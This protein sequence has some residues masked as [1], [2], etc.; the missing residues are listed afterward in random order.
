MCAYIYIYIYMYTYVCLCMNMDICMHACM[1]VCMYVG[2]YP[3]TVTCMCA[4]MSLYVYVVCM[5]VRTYCGTRT[6]HS[7]EQLP[8]VENS[9]S[10]CKS[11]VQSLEGWEQQNSGAPGRCERCESSTSGGTPEANQCKG[12]LDRE[13]VKQR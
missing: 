6:G 9:C 4:R 8:H 1:D 7:L 5:H 12:T 2:M 13:E 11:S 10:D 3:C